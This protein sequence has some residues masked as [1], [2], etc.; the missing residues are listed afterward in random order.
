MEKKALGLYTLYDL[1]RLVEE[2]YGP[3]NISKSLSDLTL[4]AF[5]NLALLT[6]GC[7]K[8]DREKIVMGTSGL[9]AW[10]C[11]IINSLPQKPNFD[12]IVHRKFPCCPYCCEI[13][14]ICGSQKGKID[15]VGLAQIAKETKIPKDI[16]YW[17]YRFSR[18]YPNQNLTWSNIIAHL[19]EELGE[20][21][22]QT[23]G[24]QADKFPQPIRILNLYN[25][26]ADGV[27][28][29]FAVCDKQEIQL[30]EAIKQ[31]F[32]EMDLCLYCGQKPCKCERV[33]S[34]IG[35]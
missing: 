32:T 18:I 29:L 6:Q 12:K 15:W 14:C 3:K 16:E 30:I 35:M 9:I 1:Q 5:T 20:I 17:Q 22:S 2:I 23:M 8:N 34:T 25:E 19:L 27:A 13:P 24:I 11:A 4:G 21:Y 7:R 31:R 33:D 26:I 10:L 28:W